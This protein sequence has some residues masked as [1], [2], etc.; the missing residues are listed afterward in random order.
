MKNNK[1]KFVFLDVDGVLNNELY[2]H[3]RV[4]SGQPK[5][6]D[7]PKSEFDPRCIK[8]LNHLQ[9]KTGCK[10][11]I[12]SSWRQG[13]TIDELRELFSSVGLKGEIIDKTPK[14]W[15]EK[16]QG[17]SYQSVPRGCEIHSWL[18]NHKEI[19]GDS[20]GNFKS[21]VILDDDSDMLFWQRNNYIQVDAYCGLTPTIIARAIR[22]LNK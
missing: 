9:E 21:Y 10:Y 15:F 13:K 12:S 7:Y 19:L 5:E 18:Q 22:I 20:I 17:E 14:M 3:E 8:M 6:E 2:Y 16:A 1:N 4:E 11:V